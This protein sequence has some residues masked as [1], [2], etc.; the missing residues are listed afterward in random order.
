[1]QNQPMVSNVNILTNPDYVNHRE[2]FDNYA[3]KH[4]CTLEFVYY[5]FLQHRK[6]E[7]KE[8]SKRIDQQMKEYE[9]FRLFY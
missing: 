2:L 8:Q 5:L 3:H 1:M 4:N 9:T 7:C 6:T